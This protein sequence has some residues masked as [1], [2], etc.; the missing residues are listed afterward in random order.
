MGHK[1]RVFSLRKMIIHGF[2]DCCI[3][4]FVTLACTI[5]KDPEIGQ[6]YWEPKKWENEYT[7]C[8]W[9]AYMGPI[10][11]EWPNRFGVLSSRRGIQDVVYRGSWAMAL[12]ILPL[13]LAWSP[14]IS[15]SWPRHHGHFGGLSSS[16][17]RSPSDIRQWS[18][19]QDGC[20]L[21]GCRRMWW[22]GVLASA[23]REGGRDPIAC[24]AR[25][26]FDRGLHVFCVCKDAILDVWYV[27]RLCMQNRWYWYMMI[28]NSC[29]EHTFSIHMYHIY[30]HTCIY[31]YI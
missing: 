23:Q 10:P 16:N 12:C 9:S 8:A 4:M 25:W 26:R 30:I 18:E 1:L 31:I 2:G 11:S 13:L 3:P 29:Y 19:P 28:F 20:H 27:C 5:T 24:C 6:N 21:R 14:A 7:F 15:G 22:S 17:R